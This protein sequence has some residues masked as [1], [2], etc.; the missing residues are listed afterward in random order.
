M[1]VRVVRIVIAFMIAPGLYPAWLAIQAAGDFQQVVAWV[2]AGFSYAAAI[3]L[4]VP[5]L[6][7]FQA[8]KLFAWWY[9][10]LGATLIALIPAV[11]N[12]SG[13]DANDQLRIF[14]SFLAI[15]AVSGLV[16]WIIGIWKSNPKTNESSNRL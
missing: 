10:V 5:T 3:I 16:F 1:S 14:G 12:T 8:K 13:R 9:Y 6:L 11:L 7:L 2:F 15:G 4:G